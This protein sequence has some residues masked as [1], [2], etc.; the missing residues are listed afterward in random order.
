MRLLLVNAKIATAEET[1]AGNILI[2]DGVIA[3]IDASLNEKADK[4]V[5]LN[6]KYLIPGGVDVHT[7]FNLDV[8]IAV[9]ADDFYTGTVA[10][11]CGGTT[12]IIDHMGFGPAGCDLHHQLNKYKADAKTDAVIDYGF[13]GVIQ[14]LNDD[15]LDEMKSMVDDGVSSFKG[16]MTYDYKLQDEQMKEIMKRLGS[17]G[18]MTTVHAEAHEEIQDLRAKYISEGR[19]NAIYHAKSRPVKSE[20]EAIERMIKISAEADDA[21]LYVVHLSSGDGLDVI[22]KAREEGRNIYAETCPQYLFLNEDMYLEEDSD[23]LKYVMSPPLREVSNNERLWK[24]IA[25]GSIQTVATDH[26]PFD[27]QFK[28]ELGS[29]DFT[30]CPNGAPGVEARMTLMYSEGVNKNRISI[31]RFVDV[32]STTPAKLFG[33]YPKKGSISVGADADLVVIDPDRKGVIKHENLHENVDYTPYE[34]MEVTGYPVMT[35]SRGEII[36]EEG[37]FMGERGRGNFLKREAVSN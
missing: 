3:K 29:K 13:H 15:I 36:V 16:Y 23:G 11:A 28:K 6:G 7:H 31:N 22:K 14:H 33:L 26:C 21:P 32:V 34:G 20:V 37:Q 35:I 25:D 17:L 8:G 30:R 2:E 18:A 9:A 1:F 27:L 4:V 10:A 24:G 5:D 19:T 12:T